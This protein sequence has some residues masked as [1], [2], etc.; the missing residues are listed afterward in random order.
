LRRKRA[1]K[2]RKLRKAKYENTVKAWKI[3]DS[4]IR[5]TLDPG[6]APPPMFKGLAEPHNDYAINVESV[7]IAE[8]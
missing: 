4:M 8:K 6:Y 7:K 2:L 3:L 5:E 1:R